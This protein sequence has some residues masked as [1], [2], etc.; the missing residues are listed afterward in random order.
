LWARVWEIFEADRPS[1]EQ[2]RSYLHAHRVHD[3]F[4]FAERFGLS[5]PMLASSGTIAPAIPVHPAWRTDNACEGPSTVD[6][7]GVRDWPESVRAP[8]ALAARTRH[9][10][11]GMY[12]MPPQPGQR[13]GGPLG[14]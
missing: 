2:E 8:L 3:E 11:Q 9:S 4:W 10:R 5:W 7:D 1:V 13:I 14:R 6:E 12:T